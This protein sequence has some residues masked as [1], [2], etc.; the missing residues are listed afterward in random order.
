MEATIDTL[1]DT[2]AGGHCSTASRVYPFFYIVL[3]S[4]RPW[5][6]GARYGLS[7][8]DEIVLGRSPERRAVR[9]QVHGQRQLSIRLP[10]RAISSLHARIRQEAGSWV[11]E[12]AGSTNG[13]LINGTK[14]S[15]VTL[16]EGDL[17]EIGHCIL[18]LRS[19][20]CAPLSFEPDLDPGTTTPFNPMLT[21]LPEFGRTLLGL[22]RIAK[23]DVPVVLVG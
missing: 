22:R 18:T 3:E 15:R 1:E 8:V 13:S 14:V 12:D 16:A 5:A 20:V 6:G 2:G 17:V 23:S 10:G 9:E 11:F 21:L 4:D 19:T 7:A